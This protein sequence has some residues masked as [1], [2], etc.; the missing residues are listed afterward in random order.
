MHV[1]NAEIR[2]AAKS[3]GIKQWQLADT[4]GISENTLIRRL[5][6]PLNPEEQKRILAAIDEIAGAKDCAAVVKPIGKG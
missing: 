1:E 5:R 2:K 3:A 4:L 6:Y